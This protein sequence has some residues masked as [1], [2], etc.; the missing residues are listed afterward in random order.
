MID[1]KKVLIWALAGLAVFA[2]GEESSD[3]VSK[4]QE[5]AATDAEVAG[6]AEASADASSEEPNPFP[7]GDGPWAEGPFVA[8][9]VEETG[10]ENASTLFHPEEFAPEE[11]PNPIIVWGN[12]GG[13]SP[14]WY[15]MLPHL[16]T[17]GFV[18]IAPNNTIVTGPE[19]RAAVEW[20]IEQNEDSSSD[21][22]NKLDPE[23]VGAMGYSNGSLAV[24]A[25]L[26]DPDR[27]E[28]V[29]TVHVSGGIWVGQPHDAILL[30]PGPTAYFCDGADTK[31]NC[32][33]DYDVVEVPVFYGTLLDDAVHISIPFPPYSERVA[34]AA[35]AWFRWHLM[36][37][38]H[39]E[40]AFVGED[41]ELCQDPNWSVQQKGWD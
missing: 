11:A 31:D 24:Y 28:L 15:T 30:E 32:D 22:Y 39:L 20:L 4:P 13:T 37:Q 9:T 19:L 3:D 35:T 21:F 33:S 6:D 36:G 41:C 27:P 38:D 16:A 12:G 34:G 14:D 17:H 25:M 23:K 1:A 26:E 18:V 2:C 5:A 40:S 8:I 29:T 7:E 10:P